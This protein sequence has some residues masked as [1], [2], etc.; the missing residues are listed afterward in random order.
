MSMFVHKVKADVLEITHKF[1]NHVEIRTRSQTNHMDISPR[2]HMECELASSRLILYASNW[3]NH[4]VA[5]NISAEKHAF[6]IDSKNVNECC[7]VLEK[8]PLY[9]KYQIFA[10]IVAVIKRLQ[11]MNA[12]KRSMGSYQFSLSG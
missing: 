5:E 2:H 11:R 12:P 9:Q 1:V 3:L 7:D 4:L 8:S 6:Y 10:D